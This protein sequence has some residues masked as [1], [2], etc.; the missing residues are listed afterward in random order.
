MAASF[1]TGTRV[2]LHGLTTRHDYN[3]RV[4]VLVQAL[5]VATGRCVVKLSDGEECSLRHENL[6]EEGCFPS[7]RGRDI[8]SRV[9][10]HGLTA[11]PHY[12]SRVGIVTQA[13]QRDGRCTVTLCDGGEEVAVRSQNLKDAGEESS[14]AAKSAQATQDVLMKAVAFLAKFKPL[15][16]DDLISKM[17]IKDKFDFMRE[18]SPMHA[19][20]TA[21]LQSA[22]AMQQPKTDD[23]MPTRDVCSASPRTQDDD[24]ASPHAPTFSFR[25]SKGEAHCVE[26]EIF[27][28][29]ALNEDEHVAVDAALLQSC[30]FGAA[31]PRIFPVRDT[32]RICHFSFT[33]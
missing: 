3:G 15:E 9:M 26:N 18:G 27:D 7:A 4:G 33:V 8:G 32:K 24:G 17:K 12:N 16:R 21:C 13:A 11:Q 1:P 19:V 2:I 28:P 22:C 25:W 20:F 30:M 6:T 14:A 31:A 23:S 5:D 10:L 29:S